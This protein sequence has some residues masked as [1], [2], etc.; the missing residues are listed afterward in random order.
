MANQHMRRCSA[1]LTIRETHMRTT[2]GS[3]LMLVRVGIPNQTP[4][5]KGMCSGA[6]TAGY[7]TEALPKIKN[8]NMTHVIQYSNC[9]KHVHRK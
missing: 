1:A 9:W 3:H 6:A 8:R 5:L 7:S 4:A 2:V